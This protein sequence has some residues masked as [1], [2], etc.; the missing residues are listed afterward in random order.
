MDNFGSVWLL[1]GL[2]FSAA[3]PGHLLQLTESGFHTGCAG[4]GP[5][6]EELFA[7][8]RVT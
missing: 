2:F 4:F 1:A 8:A 5:G 6:R 3:G 7:L